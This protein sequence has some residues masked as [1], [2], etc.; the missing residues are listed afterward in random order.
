MAVRE[1]SLNEEQV[2]EL[3][4]CYDGDRPSLESLLATFG[5]DSYH[6]KSIAILKAMG[7]GK[8]DRVF[9]TGGE[10]GSLSSDD[11]EKEKYEALIGAFFS[12][13]WKPEN[14]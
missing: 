4:H 11:I 9:Y 8:N 13:V 1:L 3:R 14:I 12:G 7:I 10:D 2:G 6:D 5:A